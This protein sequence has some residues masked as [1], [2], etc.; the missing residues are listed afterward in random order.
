MLL[1][2]FSRQGQGK[3][4]L[5]SPEAQAELPACPSCL[6]ASHPGLFCLLFPLPPLPIDRQ[7][8]GF[9]TEHPQEEPQDGREASF[10]SQLVAVW[11]S[12]AE[13][14]WAQDVPLAHPDLQAA[15]AEDLWWR[16]ASRAILNQGR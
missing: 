16:E 7:D 14:P 8:S 6:L 10:S 4:T 3:A 9:Q 11:Q 15:A 13:E 12:P 2:A 1:Q 5:L